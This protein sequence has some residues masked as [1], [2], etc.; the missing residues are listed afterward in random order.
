VRPSPVVDDESL[1]VIHGLGIFVR[2]GAPRLAG[3]G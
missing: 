2:N 1:D 3:T